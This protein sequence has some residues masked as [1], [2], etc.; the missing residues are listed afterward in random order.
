[1]NQA[2]VDT[3]FACDV[4]QYNY[5]N[6]VHNWV[7]DRLIWE[8]LINWAKLHIFFPTFQ[9]VVTIFTS[10]YCRGETESRRSKEARARQ[11]VRAEKPQSQDARATIQARP[12]TKKQEG[13]RVK[14]RLS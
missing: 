13:T 6:I 4:T 1:M 7:K 2:F 9:N 3:V 14:V 8:I 10:F 12:E 5:L 11:I